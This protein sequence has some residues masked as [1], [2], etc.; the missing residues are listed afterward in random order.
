[1]IAK[2]DEE[3]RRTNADIWHKAGYTGKGIH[4]VMIDLKATPH[5]HM[6]YATA[7]FADKERISHGTNTTQVA[8]EFAPDAR[9]TMLYSGDDCREWFKQH[10]R[11]IDVVNISLS[12]IKAGAEHSFG[13]L[14]EYEHIPVFCSSGNDSERDENGVN[15]PAAFDWTI[16]VGAYED[17]DEAL[18]HY[19]NGGEKLDLLGFTDIY[20]W[21]GDKN[22]LKYNGTSTSS[23]QVAGSIACYIQYLKEN[24]IDYDRETIREFIHEHAIDIGEKG[25]DYASGW[26]LFRLPAEI[27]TVEKKPVEEV[28]PVVKYKLMIDAGHGGKDPGAVSQYGHEDDYTL[29]ISLYQYKRFKELGVSVGITRDSD[30]TLTENERVALAQHGEYCISNHLNAGGGDRAE[31]IHSIYDDGKLANKIK[32]QLLAVGQNYVKVYFRNGANGDYYYMHRRTGAT[33]TNIVEYCFIDN[34][35]DFEH[36]KENM[37]DYAE[38]VVKAFCSHIGHPYKQ[39]EVGKVVKSDISG[40]WAEAALTK[41]KKK[42]I[43]NGYP[44]GD[45][46]L[47]EPLTRAQLAAI[48]D[49]L[50]LLD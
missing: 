31:V 41:A 12:T 5:A 1:M 18:A 11:E 40:H 32:D 16:A 26:G 37:Y 19:S 20:V 3:R 48:L 49:R 28:K 9:I 2:N 42:G 23:P 13:F 10:A 6:T 14:E 50:G 21:N 8:H 46:K 7:P 43:I 15:Y 47:D 39:K 35:A 45:M 22:E 36:F 27:P 34:K 4:I 38:S 33:K 24:E 30:K 25:F 17:K 44:G 29:L